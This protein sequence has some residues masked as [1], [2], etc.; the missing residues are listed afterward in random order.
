MNFF[1]RKSA[2]D[3]FAIRE[4][5]GVDEQKRFKP[6]LET[7]RIV[8]FTMIIGL[9][10][11]NLNTVKKRLR[12]LV[13]LYVLAAPVAS[14]V[15]LDCYMSLRRMD[16]INV[17]RHCTIFI[18]FFVVLIK[19]YLM[20]VNRYKAKEIIDTINS[21][22]AR[23]NTLS[24]DY[25]D[26]VTD[27]IKATVVFEKTWAFCVIGCVLMFPLMAGVQTLYSQLFDEIPKKY[28]IHDT[29]KPFSE[30]EARFESPFFEIMFVY[31][32]VMALFYW[33]NFTGYDGM[34]GVA[35]FH[36]CLK[37]KMY[38]HSLKKAFE[39]TS[40]VQQLRRRIAD[41]IQEQVEVYAFVD[42]IQETFNTWLGIILMGTITQICNCMYQ[43]IEGDFDLRYLVFCCG[44]I[45]HIF[46]PCR[47][48]SELKYMSTETSTL[49]Y[50]CGWET[51]TDKSTRRS[52]MFMIARG[53]IPLEITAFN[54]FAFEME[55][56]LS[57]LQTS[58]SMF[59]LLR[60]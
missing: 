6:F 9:I 32:F 43:I 14:T 33:V 23:Y 5:D 18:P 12:I 8:A 25:Q 39:E 42:K 41:V 50:L 37:M 58:Y 46:L 57:I 51:V 11:P 53:Q 22:H 13:F 54:M 15:V 16:L 2:E 35:V 38:C 29:N 52:I 49:I 30:P 40:D 45:V 31:M 56:F 26:I 7:Y 47:N 60:D 28:M 24:E 44:T 34:F 19:M 55:L 10:F 17:T 1:K 20:N 4:T 21:D 3:V 59:T 48:A 36:A 27:N